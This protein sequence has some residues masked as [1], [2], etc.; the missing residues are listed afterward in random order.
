MAQEPR[1]LSVRPT[2]APSAPR[3]SRR[4]ATVITIGA[5]PAG[6]SCCRP[7][8]TCLSASLQT[9]PPPP[10]T[11]ATEA[12]AQPANPKPA[13][14]ATAARARRGS[15]RRRHAGA[16]RAGLCTGRRHPHTRSRPDTAAAWCDW[17]RGGRGGWVRR[18]LTGAHK[19][20]AVALSLSTLVMV[21]P[22]HH[23]TPQPLP[24]SHP[25][26]PLPPPSPNSRNHL[27]RFTEIP[28]RRHIGR[29]PSP[30]SPHPSLPAPRP[31]PGPRLPLVSCTPAHP[32]IRLAPRLS[33][34]RPRPPLRREWAWVWAWAENGATACRGG[35]EGGVPARG[36]G[37]GAYR[38][39]A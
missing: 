26:P 24:P 29:R 28:Q 19:G 12:A 11:S 20:L 6:G 7:T 10:P 9:S 38:R 15:R 25:P 30:L 3:L 32:R 36:G 35:G 22:C 2:L 23:T 16:P 14:A 18:G 39:S 37:E 21:G 5:G 1:S 4:T 33:R 34:P 17:V 27:S 8:R 31:F 13:P